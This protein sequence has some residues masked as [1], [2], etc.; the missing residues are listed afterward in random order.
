MRLCSWCDKQIYYGLYCS[1]ECAD[2]DFELIGL[3]RDAADKED[4]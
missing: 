3:L 4:H 2:K 1:N